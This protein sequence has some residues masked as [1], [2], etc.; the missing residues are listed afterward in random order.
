MKPLSKYL[1][2]GVVLAGTVARD[3]RQ[4]RD[5]PRWTRTLSKTTLSAEL[6][7]L[8]FVVIDRLEK[9]LTRSSKV[10]EFGGGGST[11]WFANRV[12]EVVTV[13]HD[14]DWFPVLE[15]AVGSRPGCTLIHRTAQDNYADYITSID[16]FEDATFDAVVVDGRERVR[17]LERALTKVRPGGLLV[18]DDA[19]RTRYSAAYS[20]AAGWPQR[21]YRGLA[22]TMTVPGVTAVWQ[23]PLLDAA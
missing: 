8:P 19:N 7:W 15:S 9:H 2:H 21:T 3:P 14:P 4:V 23:R 11:V 18:L 5:I 22:P 10:F 12:G 6:P 13:E 16:P 20:L 17:C 1:H